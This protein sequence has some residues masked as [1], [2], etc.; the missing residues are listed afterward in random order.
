MQKYVMVEGSDS[1]ARD[2]ETGAIININSSEI[3]TARKAKQNRIQKKQEFENLK[4]EV[5]E[6]KELLVQLLE[7]QNGN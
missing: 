6:I 5:S 3:E 4:N 7:K 1:F 2:V